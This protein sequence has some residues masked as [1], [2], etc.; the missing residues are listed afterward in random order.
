MGEYYA[1][2]KRRK[3]PCVSQFHLCEMLRRG[4]FIE[5]LSKLVV[6]RGWRKEI[7]ENDYK[8]I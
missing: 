2:L 8:W 1:K 3:R 4:E 7:I 5:T 6:A